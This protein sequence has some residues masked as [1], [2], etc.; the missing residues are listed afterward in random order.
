MLDRREIGRRETFSRWPGDTAS[1]RRRAEAPG[2]ASPEAL[3]PA[4]PLIGLLGILACCGT[5]TEV[6]IFKAKN[7]ANVFN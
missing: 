1:D 6:I 3:Q 2:P 5:F 7:Y 4:C